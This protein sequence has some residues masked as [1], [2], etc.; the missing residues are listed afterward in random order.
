MH[1]FLP[2]RRIFLLARNLLDSINQP[3]QGGFR[4]NIV[5]L[6]AA[7]LPRYRH[8]LAALMI[9]AIAHNMTPSF[10]QSRGLEQQ[11]IAERYFHSLR[12]RLARHELLLWVALNDSGLVGSVQLSI[13]QRPDGQNRAE[14]LHLLVHSQTRREGIGHKLMQA[15]EQKAEAC[16]RGL[17]YLDVMAGSPAEAFYRAQG[18]HYL[19]ELPD[20]SLR[21]DGHPHPGVIYYKRLRVSA[22]ETAMTTY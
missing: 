6:N 9:D 19:G 3:K 13:C 2:F 4:M 8:A 18:Y 15:L 7:T 14:V 1:D 22:P 20:Y 12:D 10:R 21:A 17:L 16:H 11:Q 5:L